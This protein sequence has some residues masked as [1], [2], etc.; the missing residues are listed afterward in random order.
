VLWIPTVLLAGENVGLCDRQVAN[1]DFSGNPQI[2]FESLT[3]RRFYGLGRDIE[4][5]YLAGND[6]Q[7]KILSGRVFEF[8]VQIS[9]Q[10]EL[11]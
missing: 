8:G 5:A 2:Q 9:L 1:S 6:N 4:S 10:L 11:R 3:L 7:V